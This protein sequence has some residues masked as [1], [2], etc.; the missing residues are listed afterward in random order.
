MLVRSALSL[1]VLLLGASAAAASLAHASAE[2]YPRFVEDWRIYVNPSGTCSMSGSLRLPS[3]EIVDFVLTIGDRR[4]SIQMDIIASR[5]PSAPSAFEKPARL[6]IGGGGAE[7]EG[8]VVQVEGGSTT[9]IFAWDD[10]L[11]EALA[12]SGQIELTSDY[13]DLRLPLPPLG[14]PID[15]VLECSSGLPDP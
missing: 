12:A 3:R 2:A 1:A 7:W 8:A 15:A 13:F 14:Q 11:I 4:E 10:G 5:G 9:V 6:L